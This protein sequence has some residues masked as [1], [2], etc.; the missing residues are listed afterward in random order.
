MSDWQL[1]ETA[2]KD[3]TII[4]V[5]APGKELGLPDF[6]GLCSWHEDAGFCICELRNPTHW[7]PFYLPRER[8]A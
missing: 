5:F 2:P 6:V 4:I 7:M 3:G 8:Y 1:I